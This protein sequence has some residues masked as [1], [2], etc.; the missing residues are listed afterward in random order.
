MGTLIFIGIMFTSV[1]PMLLIMK[2]ADTIYEQEK[3]EIVRFDDER[4]R[5]EID[6]YCY[7][8]GDAAPNNLTIMIHNRCE[9]NARTVRIWINDTIYPVETII[10]SMKE[11]EI[12]SYNLSPKEGSAFDVL[13]TTDRGNIFEPTSGAIMYQSG[14]WQ[15]E[16]KL[17]NVLISSWGFVFTIYLT[18]PDDS[19]H[20]DSPATVWKI[21]GTATKIF[22]ITDHGNGEYNVLIKRGITTIHDEN[23]TMNWPAGP[24]VLWVYS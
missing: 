24:S 3:L 16:Q 8:T 20:P 13:V 7:P 14:S 4:S 6:V 18:L 17:I 9:L 22:D 12:A 19:P 2:Q 1:V 15:V 10:N 11:E 5:E 21:G 23:V